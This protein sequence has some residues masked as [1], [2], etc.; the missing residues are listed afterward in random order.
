MVVDYAA[1]FGAKNTPQT[2]PIPG[3]KM[4][5]NN[6]GGFVFEINKWDQMLRFL[7][8]GCEG[9]T[10]YVG[11]NKLSSENAANTVACIQEDTLKAV[12]LIKDVSLNG[13]SAKQDAVIFAL[14][15]ACTFSKEKDRPIAYAAI[16]EVCRIG[17]HIFQ[18][19]SYVNDLRKWSRGLR[20]GISRFYTEKS[21]D[22]L[23]LQIIK[24]RN[25][26]GYTHRDVM[27]L[28]HPVAKSQQMNTLFK[29]A[30]GK[31]DSMEEIIATSDR[32]PL[33][34]DFEIAKT[35]D[36]S[37]SKDA[38]SLIKMITDSRMPREAIPT[39]FLKNVDVWSALLVNMPI[40]AMVRNLGKMSSLGMTSS[41]LSEATTAIVSRLGDPIRIKYSRVHPMQILVAMKIYSQGHGDRG[42]LSWRPNAK[43]LDALNRAFHLSFGNVEATGLNHMLALDVSGSMSAQIM[44]SPLNCREASA[45]MAMITARVED[46]HDFIGFTSGGKNTFSIKNSRTARM[47]GGCGVSQLPISPTQRLDDVIR[48]ISRLP[49]GGTDCAL[50]MQYATAKKIPVDCFHVYTDNETSAGGMHPKQALDEY[51]QKMGRDAKLVVVG[52]TASKFSIADPK[53]PGMFDVCGFD[54]ATPQLISNF[55][56]GF[57]A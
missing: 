39:G 42:S 11:E 14:A 31:L 10:Y 52:M 19:T 13:R 4:S 1:H 53:D 55:S 40:G 46:N 2:Q 50:P 48:S 56:L 36:T 3:R 5:K 22:K 37:S 7:I 15:L 18:F 35:F 9:G 28:A 29:Y 43:I 16:K 41:N 23:E 21:L 30:V 24:Y 47:W 51:R 12:E 26:A 54:T 20:T 57:S 45:A 38:K 27:R 17:T 25:R 44:G 33:L 32:F 6:A 49:F 8:L 34:R